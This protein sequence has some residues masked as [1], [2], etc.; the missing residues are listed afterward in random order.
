MHYVLVYVVFGLTCYSGWKQIQA[1]K[2]ELPQLHLCIPYTLLVVLKKSANVFNL[3]F[4]LKIERSGL[5][6]DI[7]CSLALLCFLCPVSNSM[8]YNNEEEKKR[9]L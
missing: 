8:F 7:Q 4:Q 5:Q 9:K 2:L 3:C 6:W 1:H